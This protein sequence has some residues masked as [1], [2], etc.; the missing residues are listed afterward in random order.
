MEERLCAEIRRFV[1]ESPENRF[2]DSDVPYFDEPLVGFAAADDPLFAAY[3]EIIGPFHLTPRE[4]L[5]PSGATAATVISWV[6]PVVGS[7]RE[8]NRRENRWPSREWAL[9][10][11]YGEQLNGSLRRH[12]VAWL[13]QQG[14]QAV[15]PQFSPL[16]QEYGD[17][18]VGIASAWSERH[19]AYVCGLGTFS[20]ND[21]LITP[22]GIAHRLGS[23]VTD[24][25]L[26]PSARP[27]ADHRWC[28]LFYREGTCGACI[29]RCPVGA[30]S[31]L[32]H[33]KR[34]CRDLVYGDAPRAVGETYGV[35]HTGCGLCQTKVPCEGRIPAGAPTDS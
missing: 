32:G 3:R 12:V 30:L 10:R 14:Y 4:V 28:C 7:T 16:W 6:L 5:A 34:K 11:S 19:A 20:L 31:R 1:T 21:A 33:D 22:R 35:P 2:S 29:G 15:A 23:V 9:T 8:S 27:Y 17:S 18:P 24:L 26:T 25:R 13:E